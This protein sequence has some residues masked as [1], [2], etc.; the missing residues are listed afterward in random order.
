MP[1]EIFS[2]ILR[3]HC[4]MIKADSRCSFEEHSTACFLGRRSKWEGILCHNLLYMTDIYCC[5][6]R[7]SPLHTMLLCDDKS[8]GALYPSDVGLLIITI[9]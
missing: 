4:D 1:V 2:L 5:F 9:K 7:Y 3:S 6:Q 8:I